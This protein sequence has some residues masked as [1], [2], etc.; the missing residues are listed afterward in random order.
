MNWIKAII[1]IGVIGLA[2][3][4]CEKSNNIRNVDG[5]TIETIDGHE[6]IRSFVRGGHTYTHLESCRYCKK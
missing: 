3:M 2:M 1:I 5:H 4:S 6:Y